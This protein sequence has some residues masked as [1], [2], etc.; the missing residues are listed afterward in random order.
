MDETII[1]EFLDGADPEEIARNY[2]VAVERV[3]R[4]LRNTLR[5]HLTPHQQPL[6]RT[7]RVA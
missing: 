3:I 1:A 2:G 6:K 4:V 5:A 7:A